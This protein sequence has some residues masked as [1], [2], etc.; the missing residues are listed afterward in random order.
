MT[1]Q[2]FKLGEFPMIVER[3]K[4]NL[5]VG[6]SILV[7]IKIPKTTLDSV[8]NNEISIVDNPQ[9]NLIMTRHSTYRFDTSLIYIFN[10][11]FDLE[12]IRGERLDNDYNFE[13]EETADDFAL[14]LIYIPRK[15]LSYSLSFGF[16]EI[17][18]GVSESEMECMEGNTS[19]WDARFLLQTSFNE[20][21]EIVGQTNG[22]QTTF[23]F[24][25]N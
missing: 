6:D 21:E 14:E 3:S 24:I 1:E 12:V 20:Y 13:M 9:L 22:N 8:T 15:A 7:D 16:K 5:Q 4:P 19:N 25:V 17:D 23:G 2:Q 10:E 18:L 11:W